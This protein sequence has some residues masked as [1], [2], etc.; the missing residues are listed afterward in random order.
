MTI[1]TP[2]RIVNIAHRGARAFAPENTLVA[3]AKA[4]TLGCEMFEMD[5]QLSKDGEVVV[6]HDEHLL[7]CTDAKIR[8]PGRDNYNLANYTYQELNQLDAG[9]WYVEQLGLCLNDR[10]PFLQSLSNSEKTEF[11]SPSQQKYYASGDIK[12]PT[13]AE[14]FCLAKELGLRV[15]V[16][17]KSQTKD[18]TGLVTAVLRIVKIMAMED[19]ILISSFDHEGLRQLRQQT[20]KIAIGILTDTPI[21]GPIGYLRKFKANAY[22]L[23]CYKD[24]QLNGF[25]GLSGKRYLANIKKVRDSGFE[26]NVWTCNAPEEMKALVLAGITGLISDYP[27]RVRETLK[28]STNQGM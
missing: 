8:F 14:T 9:S 1:R 25:S 11:V 2:T 19:Q 13:L 5:V 21:H 12:I 15:N 3:F 4:K 23:G 16:E 20:K 24:F 28:H 10:Q 18:A 6:F 26:V 22:N 17:L 7:R 27:N